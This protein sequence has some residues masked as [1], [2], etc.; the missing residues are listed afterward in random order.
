MDTAT[1]FYFQAN[2]CERRHNGRVAIGLFCRLVMGLKRIHVNRNTLASNKKWGKN[3]PVVGVEERGSKKRY[4]HRVDI[5]HGGVIVASIIHEEEHP[6]RCGARCWVET[7][8]D[9]VVS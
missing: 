2:L 5:V 6:L 3:D 4:G 8:Q 1:H 9:V 7:Q